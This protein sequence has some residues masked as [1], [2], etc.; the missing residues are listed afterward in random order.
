MLSGSKKNVFLEQ[1]KTDSEKRKLKGQRPDYVLYEKGKDTPLIV[2]ETKK[3]GMNISTA[4]EQGKKYAEILNAPIVFATDGVYYKSLHTET[5]KPLLL[6][7]EEVDELIRELIAIQFLQKGTN[8]LETIPKEIRLSR[9]QLIG[10]FSEANNTLRVEGLRAGIERFSEFANILFLK[11]FS[12]IDDQKEIPDVDRKLKW[13]FYKGK[14]A[15]EILNYINDTVLLKISKLYKDDNIFSPLQI[16]DGNVLKKIIDKLDP[17]VLTDINSDIKGDAFEYFLKATTATGNDLGEYFTPRHIVKMM[18]KLVNPQITEKIYD[19]FCGTG[20]LLIES[21]RHI[22]NTMPHNESNK[23]LLK[24]KTIYGNE[25]TNTARITKMNMI[26][27]GDGHSNIQMKNS[28]A[29][30]SEI[31]NRFDVVVTNMPYSQTTEYGSLYDIPTKNGD[32]ICVQHCI[33]AIDKTADNGRIAMVVPEG[34]LFRKDLQKTR[35]YM[36]EKCN[37]QSLISLPQGVFLPYTGVKTNVLFLTKIKQK[38]QQSHFWYFDI[39]NDGFSLDNNRRKLDGE[40]DIEKYLSNRKIDEKNQTEPLKVGFHLVDLIKVSQNDFILSGGRYK[41]NQPISYKWSSKQIKDIAQVINGFAFSSDYFN[42]NDGIPLIRVRDIN[43]MSTRIKFNGKYKEEYVV[44]NG[45]LL[46]GMDG[47]FNAVIW[48]GG[49]A[50]LNQRVCKIH[51]FKECL[52][53]YVY[54]FIQRSLKLIEENTPFTTVKH[55][56]AKQIENIEIPLPPIETQL[57]LINELEN[58][59]SIIDGAKTITEKYYPKVIID[60]KWK[61]VKITTV[62]DFITGLTLSIP[63]SQVAN[64]VPIISMNSITEDGILKHEGIRKIKLPNKK[65]VNYLQ[66]GD[67]LFNWRNGSQ[68]LVGKTGHFEFDGKYVFASFLLGLRPKKQIINPKYLW[69]LLNQFRREGVYRKLM[70][71]QINGLYNRD[72]LSELDIPLPPLDVQNDIVKNIEHELKIMNANRELIDIFQL[73]ISEK[74]NQVWGN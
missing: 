35:E 2:I 56:S 44:K 47:E 46:V 10:I 16:K 67:L 12:E 54:W 4:L 31:E 59:K 48:N 13:N 15:D 64:G 37:L 36:L 62:M 26:L 21:F 41:E 51:S 69:A 24:K 29:D 50:L 43:S 55:I 53:K 17:L 32:S 66:K 74:I 42:S 8:E 49:E 52:P 40:N 68:H 61:E 70:R 57:S 45:D 25:I 71:V 20:G 58:Y 23:E 7:G 38:H 3:A 9:D 73:K 72:E 39:K 34:F 5:Q 60:P 22:Y 14:P 1:P 27:A 28:L 11:L 30:P 33:K 19:P 6:N 65:A 18:V 63:N